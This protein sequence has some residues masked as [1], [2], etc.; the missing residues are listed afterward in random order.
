[1]Q[2]CIE[3]TRET[4]ASKKVIYCSFVEAISPAHA[5]QKATMLL[6][7]YA[8]RGANGARVLNPENEVIFKLHGNA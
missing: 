8:T 2:F 5:K 4:A 7:L 6:N 1:M 3:I